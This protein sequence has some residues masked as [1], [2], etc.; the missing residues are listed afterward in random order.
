MRRRKTTRRHILCNQTAGCKPANRFEPTPLV[1]R[2]ASKVLT[3]AVA[4]GGRGKKNVDSKRMTPA[5]MKL[6]FGGPFH[7]CLSEAVALT[8]A[9]RRLLLR[10]RSR[11]EPRR[12]AGTGCERRRNVEFGMP[13]RGSEWRFQASFEPSGDDGGE[14]HG[15]YSTL[16]SRASLAAAPRFILAAGFGVRA[17]Q[18][19]SIRQG[20]TDIKNE[21]AVL[22]KRR[23]VTSSATAAPTE[24]GKRQDVS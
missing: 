18:G 15:A 6:L 24:R 7:P 16:M 17:D 13:N 4:R 3:R 11:V 2:V 19:C 9:A 10:G 21:N 12:R 8:G 1:V 23:S 14:F 20:L 5:L 22:I